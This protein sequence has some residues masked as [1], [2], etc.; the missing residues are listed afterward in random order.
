M[1]AHFTK[2][3]TLTRL[4]LSGWSK[5]ALMT[6]EW[7]GKIMSMKWALIFIHRCNKEV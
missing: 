1:L 5:K 6:I 4:Q 3:H 7:R 2:K